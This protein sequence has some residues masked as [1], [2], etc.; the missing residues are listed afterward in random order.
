M[1]TYLL[2]NCFQYFQKVLADIEYMLPNCINCVGDIL[3]SGN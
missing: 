1:Q 2:D 3:V